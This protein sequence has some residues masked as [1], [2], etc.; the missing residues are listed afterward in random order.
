MMNEAN[1]DQSDRDDIGINAT[2]SQQAVVAMHLTNNVLGAACYD[3]LQNTIFVDSWPVSTDDIVKIV[4]FLKIVTQPTLFLLHPSV[5]SNNMLLELILTGLD[6]MLRFYPFKT[7]KSSVWNEAAAKR[8]IFSTLAIKSQMRSTS[9]GGEQNDTAIFSISSAIDM[10]RPQVVQCLGALVHY[11]Q[12]EVFGLD[13]NYVLVASVESFPCDCYMRLDS[14][15]FKALQ[16]FNEDFHPNWIKGKGKSKEGFSLFGLFDRSNSPLGKNKLKS[17]MSK[18]FNNR[19][20]IIE[21]Q[22][23]VAVFADE[24]NT[25]FISEI[26]KHLRHIYDIPRLILRIKR[27]EASVLDWCKFYESLVASSEIANLLLLWRDASSSDQTIFLNSLLLQLE[28][29]AIH[30]LTGFINKVFDISASYV[31]SDLVVRKGYDSKLDGMRDAYETL[32]LQLVEAAKRILDRVQILKKLSVEYVP[33]LGFFAVVDEEN[34]QLLRETGLIYIRHSSS[35]ALSASDASTSPSKTISSFKSS[36]RE[37]DAN[38]AQFM[39]QFLRDKMYFL[40]DAIVSQLDEVI[41]DIKSDIQDAQKAIK[42]QVEEFI[43]DHEALLLTS[44]NVLASIDALTSLG[45][46]AMH[47]NLTR[48][49]LV[50]EPLLMVKG[51]RHLLQ[52]LTVDNFIPNDICSMT[53]KPISLITGPNGSG[54]SVYLKQVGLI[55]YLAHIGSW[56]PCDKAII[57]ITDRIFTRIVSDESI[58]SRQSVFAIDLNQISKMLS[59]RTTKSLCLIDEFG[60]GTTPLD[61]IALLTAI[62]EDFTSRPCRL[63]CV[64]HLTEIIE[65]QLISEAALGSIIFFRMETWK[66]LSSSCNSIEHEREITDCV[67]NDGDNSAVVPMYKLK[68]GADLSSEG[69]SCA[70]AMNI[71]AQIID[72]ASAIKF[73][74]QHHSDINRT[75][76]ANRRI[77]SSYL[78]RSDL[79]AL[80]KCA[81]SFNDPG[82]NSESFTVFAGKLL[83]T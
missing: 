67:D 46:M 53:N 10:D 31:E 13:K 2:D 40:K 68:L 75:E 35:G 57:G 62:L 72:R 30:R 43:L 55:V 81:K 14:N 73:A 34:Y 61:G 17:W 38:S 41:G 69:I 42:L 25:T 50:E 32:E 36:F 39:F 27:V 74:I 5:V 7:L 21:R 83:R 19:D 58:S 63:F 80:L 20:Q 18:P 47:F 66:D 65:R 26:S 22:R 3:E 29:N 64:L 11:L 12:N 6:G 49:E 77:E 56:V 45:A 82:Q 1:V 79:I 15:T 16:I 4:E 60:K 52:E 28:Y 24:A 33:Q 51:S 37:Y 78:S 54:K 59:F 9:H 44:S 70:K 76:L 48:P 71:S 23:A 8:I